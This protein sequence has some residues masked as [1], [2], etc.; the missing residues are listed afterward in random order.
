MMKVVERKIK[1]K[2]KQNTFNGG[3]EEEWDKNFYSKDT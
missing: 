3:K 1:N 2:M